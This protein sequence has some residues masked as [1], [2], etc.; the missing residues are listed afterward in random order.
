MIRRSLRFAIALLG[1]LIL[2]SEKAFAVK[3]CEGGYCACYETFCYNRWVDFD[4]SE[5]MVG[6]NWESVTADC[7][8]CY[9]MYG[10]CIAAGNSACWPPN[11]PVYVNLGPHSRQWDFGLTSIETGSYFDFNGDGVR[12]ATAWAARTSTAALL[13]HPNADGT[14]TTAENLFGDG[15]GYQNGYEKLESLYDTN[16]DGVISA[17]DA[18][19]TELRLWTDGQGGPD[20]LWDGIAQPS[21]LRPF[22]EVVRAFSLKDHKTGY[23]DRYGNLA[24]WVSTV[25]LV[26]GRKVQ[27][28][29]WI[30][31]PADH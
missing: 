14:V 10:A 4:H 22:L 17:L 3:Y 8:Y 15:S 30:F 9:A 7:S 12:E 1:L 19:S 16:H 25:E 6:C 2:P 13:V 29:D 28:A 20:A 18:H 31:K 23:K 21:E 26:D 24:R 5:C 27:S 11:T